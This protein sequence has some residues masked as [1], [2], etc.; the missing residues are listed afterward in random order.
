MATGLIGSLVPAAW[1]ALAIQTRA[2]QAR[3]VQRQVVWFTSPRARLARAID[4][5][6]AQLAWPVIFVCLDAGPHAY[7]CIT[8]ARLTA[9]DRFPRSSGA[10]L[11]GT[12]CTAG[13]RLATSCRYPNRL[14]LHPVSLPRGWCREPIRPLIDKNTA[15][16][17]KIYYLYYKAVN[18]TVALNIVSL[19]F[20]VAFLKL[21]SK[22]ELEK[23]NGSLA[24][25]VDMWY[26]ARKIFTD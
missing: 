25:S 1:L 24:Y 14:K 10:R 13:A 7:S 20:L 5:L 9:C 21:P 2:G 3:E 17:K 22:V 18:Q 23:I 19:F 6:H 8:A 26:F 16:R 11:V 12:F 4:W 15:G